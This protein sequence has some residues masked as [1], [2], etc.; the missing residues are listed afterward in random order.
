MAQS[1][2]VNT[3]VLALFKLSVFRRFFGVLVPAAFADWID[4]IAIMVLVSYSWDMGATE[5]AS[6]IMAATLPRVIFGLPAGVLVDRIGAGPVLIA[7]LLIRAGLMVG[8]FF[9]ATSLSLLIVF[10]FLKATVSAAFMPA[11]QLALKKI[12]P[13]NM[14][15]QAVSVDHF[16]IQST[17]IFA[18]VFGGALLAVWS[19][20]NVFLLGGASFAVASLICLS[21]LGVLK[22]DAKDASEEST[23]KSSVVNDAKVGLA[24]LWKTP[25]LLLG[26]ALICLFIF[27]VFLYE[28]V[29]L[30]LIKETGQ[31]ESAAGPILG[32][33][34]VGG[35]IG[36]YLTAKI[37]DR[38]NLHLLMVIGSF[39]GGALTIVVGWV[40]F[41]SVPFG[42]Q[43]QMALWF[44]A[45]AFTS[46]ITVPFGAII[47]KQ[48]PE[49]LLGRI[50]SVGEMLQSGLT[51]IAIP[52]G[53][54]LAEQWFISMPFFA[55]GA[56]MCGGALIGLFA[57]LNLGKAPDVEPVISEEVV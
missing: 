54:F 49:H 4:F 32:S 44:V 36:T 37:G 57:V 22:K 12:V 11:Q 33:I 41:S 18:P 10:V 42:M 47:V 14:L 43:E 7:G 13:S 8:M 28:A 5:V 35:L 39:F 26:M 50:T 21:L 34:G 15:T 51:L 6:V 45:G 27:S 19:P 30:L 48:T 17:K 31:P 29:L 40:P 16:V 46:F 9:F 23:E 3:S 52:I 25:R 55:G 24:Y 53:A 2:A 20:H 38:V 1:E 56:I